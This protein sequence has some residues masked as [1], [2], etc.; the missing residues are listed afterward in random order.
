MRLHK[1]ATGQLV[2][3]DNE[4]FKGRLEVKRLLDQ[5]C[6]THGAPRYGCA[7][8]DRHFA[9]CEEVLAPITS[10]ERRKLN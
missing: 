7:A 9:F 6:H 2:C 5:H 1:F 4:T 10:T 3:T 8:G